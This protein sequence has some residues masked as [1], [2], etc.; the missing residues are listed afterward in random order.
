MDVDDFGDHGASF[1]FCGQRTRL[2]Q[3]TR[4][5]HERAL[6]DT[7]GLQMPPASTPEPQSLIKLALFYSDAGARDNRHFRQ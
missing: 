5:L 3:Q 7:P 1:L 6:L 2:K 4:R